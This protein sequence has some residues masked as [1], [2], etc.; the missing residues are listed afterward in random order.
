M[1]L[2]SSLCLSCQRATP[3]QSSLAQHLYPHSFQWGFSHI[4]HLSA[5]HKLELLVFGLPFII[6]FPV[7]RLTHFFL[8]PVLWRLSSV[9]F[10]RNR[11]L[12][13]W[14]NVFIVAWVSQRWPHPDLQSLWICYIIWQRGICRCDSDKGP[15]D[16]E[17]TLD[18]SDGPNITIWTIKTK[19]FLWLRREMRQRW[20]HRDVKHTLLA[21]KTKEGNGE[22]ENGGSL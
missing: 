4:F 12:H 19:T 7:P 22:P 1:L 5:F 9:C 21:L 20:C 16:G 8:L 10:L 14:D 18:C 2:Y 6:L 17:N 15:W 11:K 3:S 13:F